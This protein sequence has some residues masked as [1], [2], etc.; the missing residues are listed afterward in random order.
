MARDIATAK[1]SGMHQQVEDVWVVD[2]VR[3][4]S[5]EWKCPVSRLL[6][7]RF[8]DCREQRIDHPNESPAAGPWHRPAMVIQ[9]STHCGFSLVPIELVRKSANCVP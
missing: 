3:E 2:I 9:S 4:V 8:G 5:S 6:E 7:Q 1:L